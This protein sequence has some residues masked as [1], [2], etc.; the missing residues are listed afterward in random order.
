MKKLAWKWKKDGRGGY[1]AKLGMVELQVWQVYDVGH[2]DDPLWLT[3]V[4]IKVSREYIGTL[5]PRNHVDLGKAK[6]FAE[7]TA[8]T[9]IK[10]FNKSLTKK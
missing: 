6:K 2:K 4:D 1:C 8:E 10:K 7:Q 3:A 5:Y 9:W